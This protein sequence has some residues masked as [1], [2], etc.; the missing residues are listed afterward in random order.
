MV[1]FGPLDVQLQ[2]QRR[3][4]TAKAP[5]LLKSEREKKKKILI[6]NLKRQHINIKAV[7]KLYE[8]GEHSVLSL[9]YMNMKA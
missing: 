9:S 8:D 4:E 1:P 7:I 6:S 2:R 3:V 5:W